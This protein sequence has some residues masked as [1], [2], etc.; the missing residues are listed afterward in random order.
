MAVT[1]VYDFYQKLEDEQVIL[2]FKG[3]FTSELLTSFLHILE[4][5]MVELGTDNRKKRRVF[6]VL[7]ESFQNLY[8]HIDEFNSGDS[9]TKRSALIIVK[10]VDN[11]FVVRTGNYVK[12]N[13]IQNL[14]RKLAMV[15]SLDSDELK[16]L[17]RMKLENDPRTDK[18]TAGLGLIDIARKSKS[19]LDYD[20]ID[21][22]ASSS[23][24]CL[25]VVIE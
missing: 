1:D 12:N 6:N 20:F 23:F 21:I 8:H 25:K 13:D 4:A 19:K 5:R 3:D 2:S 17:Y 7:T 10:H 9:I 18:G 11:N 16:G 14:K 15:N 24:F 22:D